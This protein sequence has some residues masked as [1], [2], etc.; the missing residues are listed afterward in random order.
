MYPY[1]WKLISLSSLSTWTL[2]QRLTGFPH[3]PACFS[4]NINTTVN[5]YL[6]HCRLPVLAC[7]T[8]TEL[9]PFLTYSSYIKVLKLTF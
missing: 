2:I 8:L 3:P 9:C 4:I 5:L 1:L 7:F 6:L